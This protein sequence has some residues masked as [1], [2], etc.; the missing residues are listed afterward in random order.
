[1][2]IGMPVYNGGHYL[3]EALASAVAQTYAPLEVTT[4]VRVTSG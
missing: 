4:H 3:A 2:S 1:M